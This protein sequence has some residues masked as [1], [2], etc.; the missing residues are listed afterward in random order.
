MEKS[1]SE[2]K[3]KV[4]GAIAKV[5]EQE[6]KNAQLQKEIEEAKKALETASSQSPDNIGYF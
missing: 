2:T 5:S 4:D 6:Q 3:S 1:I